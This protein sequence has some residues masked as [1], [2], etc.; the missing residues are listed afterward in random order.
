MKSFISNLC[1]CSLIA[2]TSSC[3]ADLS[4]A[5]DAGL[6]DQGPELQEEPT[7]AEVPVVVEPVEPSDVNSLQSLAVASLDESPSCDESRES[8][9]IYAKEQ[10]SFY[11]CESGEWAEISIEGPKGD[12][13]S[14]GSDGRDGE[15]CSIDESGLVKCGDASFQI[16]E[17]EFEQ[18]GIEISDATFSQCQDGGYVFQQFADLNGNGVRED[19]ESDIGSEQLICNNSIGIERYI[20]CWAPAL[21]S[22][23]EVSLTTPVTVEYNLSFLEDTSSISELRVDPF[24]QTVRTSTGVRKYREDSPEVDYDLYGTFESG[25]WRVEFD[26]GIDTAP[27]IIYWDPEMPGEDEREHVFTSCTGLPDL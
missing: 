16:P 9:L 19:G 17:F 27:T 14:D 11:V 22:I 3:G 13:G 15:S 24:G 10:A 20:S 4:G 6:V 12:S 2:F 26:Y 23:G 1:I 21:S 7:P 18:T 25:Y 5:G 8:Q